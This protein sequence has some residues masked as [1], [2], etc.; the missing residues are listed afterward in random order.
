MKLTPWTAPA[1][2]QLPP[3]IL[4]LQCTATGVVPGVCFL[5]KAPKLLFP[6]TKLHLSVISDISLAPWQM[7]HYSTKVVK[8]TKDQSTE[9]PQVLKLTHITE[10]LAVR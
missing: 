5:L 8:E 6:N 4:A 7:I 9:K 10:D 2:W 3:N 1:P